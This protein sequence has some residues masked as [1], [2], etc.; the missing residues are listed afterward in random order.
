MERWDVIVTFCARN[1]N[2]KLRRLRV[3]AQESGSAPFASLGGFF[4]GIGLSGAFSVSQG[5]VIFA[6]VCACDGEEFVGAFELFWAF[7]CAFHLVSEDFESVPVVTSGG[8]ESLFV[9]GLGLNADELH[10]GS[11]SSLGKF[12][13]ANV[14]M[15]PSA[16]R[17]KK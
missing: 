9:N 1:P 4:D 12:F 10:F 13:R 5:F 3:N 8:D 17:Q 2:I 7:G 15:S 11:Q 6:Q 14:G 16:Y